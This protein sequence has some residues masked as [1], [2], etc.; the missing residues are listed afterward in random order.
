MITESQD[1]SLTPHPKD[2]AC[3]NVVSLS[4]YCG[5]R[6]HAD[7][8]QLVLMGTFTPGSSRILVLETSYQ[9]VSQTTYDSFENIF[10]IAFTLP[11]KL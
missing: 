6:T 10:L 1:F 9:G 3:Y 5:I 11:I 8:P 2:S 4:L 7:H